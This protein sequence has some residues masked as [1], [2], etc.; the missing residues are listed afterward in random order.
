MV[1]S[2]NTILYLQ[3]VDSMCRC[4]WLGS[5]VPSLAS[6]CGAAPEAGVK[7]DSV[8]T[9]GCG[10]AGMISRYLYPTMDGVMTNNNKRQLS[11]LGERKRCFFPRPKKHVVHLQRSSVR[12]AAKE[13]SHRLCSGMVDG[14]AYRKKPKRVWHVRETIPQSLLSALSCA[15]QAGGLWQWWMVVPTWFSFLG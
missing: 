14:S 15:R 7:V 4:H 11:M 5:Q 1:G 13:G 9:V 10:L 8:E 3:S 2:N 6:A 12:K